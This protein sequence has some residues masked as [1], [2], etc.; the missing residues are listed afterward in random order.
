[1]NIDSGKVEV[2]VSNLWFPTGICFGED[3]T[4]AIVSV[5]FSSSIIEIP[6]QS[7]IREEYSY[8]AENLPYYPG[9]LTG[10]ESK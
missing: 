1:M 2:L 4:T 3:E 8:L 9:S 6:I 10:L 5:T 7:T